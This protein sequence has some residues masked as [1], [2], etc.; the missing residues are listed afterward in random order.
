[1]LYATLKTIH[2]LSI[3]LW[4]GG[5]FFAHFCLRPAAAALDPPQRVRLLHDTLARFF[6]FVLWAASLALL[7]G[8]AMIGGLARSEVK[9]GIQLG[10]PLDWLVMA[11]LGIVMVAVFGHIRFVL[12]RRLRAAVQ[13][14]DWPAGGVALAGIRRWVGFNLVL[15]VLIIVVTRAGE[16]V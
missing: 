6:G 5:M 2:L 3:V 11:A 12:F 10:M 16:V 13:A 1:M 15:G 14:A 7:S 4:I 8:L 9:A